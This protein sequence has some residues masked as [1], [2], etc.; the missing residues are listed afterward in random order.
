MR[1][2][3]PDEALLFNWQLGR[4][5][6][7][8]KA[9]EKWGK[10]VVE[11]V[12]P[13]LQD[14]FP[15]TKGFSTRNLWWMK[16][17]YLF[18]ASEASAHQYLAELENIINAAGQKLNQLGSEIQ[19]T[20]LSQPGS[21]LPFPPAFAYVPWRH[22]VLI[23]QKC[24]SIEEALFYVMIA[25]IENTRV[26]R[27]HWI[28]HD[29]MMN[30]TVIADSADWYLCCCRDCG[31]FLQRALICSGLFPIC[32]RAEYGYKSCCCLSREIIF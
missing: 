14:A 12:S 23:I 17:W 11:Q 1:Y 29:E 10:G 16:Q 18:Y 6:V 9:E 28:S 2:K 32:N 19:E 21:E 26:E 15:N 25:L 5:L 4:D 27:K 7:I 30:I 24:K 8:R 13:D 3:L 31:I 20:K 22:H